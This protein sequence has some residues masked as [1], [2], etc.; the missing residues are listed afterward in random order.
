[1]ETHPLYSELRARGW[2]VAELMRGL[3]V[4]VGES[5]CEYSQL[6]EMTAPEVEDAFHVVSSLLADVDTGPFVCVRV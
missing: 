4:A 1:M 6:H 2:D 5:N 3:A